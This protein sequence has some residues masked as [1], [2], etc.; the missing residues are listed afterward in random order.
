MENRVSSRRLAELLG[1]RVGDGPA[2]QWLADGI[3]LLVADGRLLHGSRLPSE[4]ELVAQLGVSRTTVT[5]AYGVLRDR[6]FARAVQ[7][8][9]TVVQVPG[10]PVAGGGEPLALATL[11]PPG[12]GVIDLTCAAPA[13]APGLHSAFAAAVEAMPSYISAA[14]YYPLGVPELRETIAARYAERGVPTDPDQIIVTTGALAALAA[15]FRAMLRRA[16]PV[17]VESPSYPNSVRALQHVG[18]RVVGAPLVTNDLPEVA[19]VIRRSGARMMLA[20]PDFH[21][22]TG[23]LWSDEERAAVAKV[24]RA[25]G[26]TGVVD[27]T[28]RDIWLDRPLDVL[29][30]AAHAP[31]CITVGSASKTFWGGLRIG[32]IRAPHA[33]VGGIARGRM[34]MDLGAPVLE[35]LVVTQLMRREGELADELRER[36]RQ[37]RQVVLGLADRCPGWQAEVPSGGLAL[38]WHLPSAASSALVAAAERRGVLLAPGSLFAVDGHGLERWVRTPYALD[39]VTLQRAVGRIAEAWAEVADEP[40]AS[41]KA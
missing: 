14:G 34:S 38:W 37:S 18:A 25:G 39:A 20:M 26:V 12:A 35:Q 2:Y 3:R 36:I 33:L 7:G 30:M 40:S 24:W 27:E 21:N 9:G 28:M 17:V 31:E 15:V 8:S 13:A 29:P 19:G 32:W 5:R 6:G 10:G 4:R 41:R 1:S 22:P 16:D 23:V 11:Q